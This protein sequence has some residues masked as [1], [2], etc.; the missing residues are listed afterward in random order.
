MTKTPSRH[1]KSS[2]T[3]VFGH[4]WC[5]WSSWWWPII[6]ETILEYSHGPKDSKNISYVGLQWQKPHQDTQ[7]SSKTPVCGHFL[8]CW[9]SWW[10]LKSLETIPVY[11]HGPKDSKNVYIG[12]QWQ[13]PHQD[14]QNPL[15]QDHDLVTLGNHYLWPTKVPF[16]FF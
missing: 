7:K 13:N 14:T 8:P 6:L 9:S 16:L 11:S 12:L 10:W 3:P 15:N 2:N 1:P 5:S 4:S